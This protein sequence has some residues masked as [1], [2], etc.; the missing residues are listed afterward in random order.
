[1]QPHFILTTYAVKSRV[2]ND[3]ITDKSRKSIRSADYKTLQVDKF[4]VLCVCLCC[5]ILCLCVNVKFC[6][7]ATHMSKQ[8]FTDVLAALNYGGPQNTTASRKKKK[9]RRLSVQF[10]RR[11]AVRP[12][13]SDPCR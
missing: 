13:S 11:T 6:L 4:T 10:R 9:Q 7:D 3:K 2:G 5:I 8:Q 12:I 1:M